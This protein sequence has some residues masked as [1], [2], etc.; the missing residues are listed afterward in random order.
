MP[1]GTRRTTSREMA[2]LL[3]LAVVIALVVTDLPVAAQD[4]EAPPPW[5]FQGEETRLEDADE[6]PGRIAPTAGQRA[7][8]EGMGATARW[9]A[10]GTPQVLVR[11]GGYLATGLD[12]DPTR[13]ADTARAWLRANAELFRLSPA[14]VDELVLLQDSPLY[15]SPDLSWHKDGRSGPD[16]PDVA[17][18]VRFRQHFDGIPAGQD[19]MVV[20]GVDRGRIFWVSS[21][22]SDGQ[23]N[24]DRPRIS[25]TA[26]WLAAAEDVGLP[27]SATALGAVTDGEDWFEFDAEGLGDVQ[28]ARL[29][30][31]PTP[32]DGVRLAWETLLLDSTPTNRQPLAFTHFVDAVDGRVW[33]RHNRLHHLA[34]PGVIGQS[35]E[36]DNPAWTTFPAYPTLVPLPTEGNL[37]ADGV[38]EDTRERW[39][40]FAGEDCDRVV[41][42]A[43]GFQNTAS[44]FPWDVD[45]RVPGEPSTFTSRGNNANTAPSCASF[46]TPDLCTF[47]RPVAPDRDYEFEWTNQWYEESCSPAVFTSPQRNDIDAATIALFVGHNRMHDWAYYLGWTEENSNMQE[48]NFGKT[49]EVR[50]QDPETG[51]TQ[52]GWT[53]GT[54]NPAYGRDNA[55][56]I[57]PPDGI[58]GVTNQ[59]LWQPI[60]SAAYVPCVDG[61]YD[62]AVVAHEVGH[63]IQHRMTAGPDTGLSG[64][65]ATS[66]GE[67][68]SDLTAVEYLSGLGLIEQG[69][70]PYAVGA[71]VVGDPERGIRNH[72]MNRSPLNYSNI[73]YDFVVRSVHSNGEIW[74]AA[75]H[76][77]REAL[78]AKYD[79][80][81]PAG[82]QELQTACAEGQLPADQCP[83]NRRWIQLMHDGFLLQPSQTTMVDARDA[84]LA[85]DVARF[86]GANQAEL[87]Q[88]FA[89]R[90]L[91]AEAESPEFT[92]ENGNERQ[93]V[94]NVDPTPD[95]TSP[96]ADNVA[97][98]FAPVAADG[99][100]APE[101]VRIFVGEYEARSRPIA[102]TDPATDL[103]DSASFA[104]DTYQ[105]LA[106]ADGFAWVRF[107][108]PLAEDGTIEIPMQRNVASRH[109]GAEVTSHDGVN[110]NKLIDDSEETNWASL[111]SD[112]TA[113]EPDD[114]EGRQVT[115]RLAGEGAQRVGRVQVSAMLR[116]TESDD[117]GDDPE[118]EP[119]PDS[120]PFPPEEP[121]GDTGGQNRFSALR[122][123]QILAC[124]AEAGQDCATEEGFEVVYTSPDD[125]FPAGPFRPRTEE[126]TLRSFDVPETEATHVRLRVLTNQCTG[127]PEYQGD[128]DNDPSNATDCRTEA[129][130]GGLIAPQ[131]ENVRAAM[132]QVLDGPQPPVGDARVRR[133]AGSNRIETAVAV[134]R[135]SFPAGADTVVIARSDLYPDALAGS[136]LAFDHE[137]P[138][139]V[140]PPESLAAPVAAEIDRLGAST[141]ILLG[142]TDALS[143]AV[144][145]AVRAREPVETVRRVEGA[146][147]FDTAAAIAGELGGDEVFITEG[148]HPHPRRGWPDALAVAPLA[149]HTGTPILLVHSDALPAP[150]RR[151]L[152]GK[153]L[154]TVVGGPTAVSQRVFTEIDAVATTT[155]RVAGDDRYATAVAVAGRA[156]STGMGVG[157]VFAATGE[158]F[159]DALVAGPAVAREGGVFVLVPPADL[160]RSPAVRRFL[161]E[162]ARRIAQITIVGGPAAVSDRVEQQLAAIMVR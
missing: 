55:N 4:T 130:A 82:D 27:V 85:A 154:A 101:N 25:A 11:H 61:A 24:A 12:P 140:T 52:A 114:V 36:Q 53:F 76:D 116:P 109:Q 32:A 93:G 69:E 54:V 81:F 14:A 123:F 67:S 143:G 50:A 5:S 113:S 56:Q 49:S 33:K 21:S 16:N 40:W 100:E 151:A 18:A 122:S 34:G 125:A 146:T 98:T 3:L 45:P 58:P 148:A 47:D 6:R 42:E 92:D 84:I 57:T 119:G 44:P 120:P 153:R 138:I 64:H 13:A 141:A 89:R 104:P 66:M 78:I 121:E 7:I 162:R 107:D 126:L 83:G 128:L 77:I 17:H 99:G 106:V 41:G 115:V 62:M 1:A 144:A 152:E 161:D 65:Q 91:G 88:A 2:T 38:S 73:E 15:D 157:H 135:A 97:V 160:D 139:L 110:S 46:L 22:L 29:V 87:W 149:A 131:G 111:G 43:E 129:G 105:F 26:A 133:L 136:P 95:F 9:N 51:Q 150:T 118:E 159:V 71:Y 96:L 37:V 63:A 103:G 145:D 72:A 80:Q 31:L 102:D 94:E 20:V 74:S 137:A 19:G 28:R 117:P 134:S 124:N 30:A 23:L 132:L 108:Q 59:Y 10:L 70:N 48:T 86:G 158:E 60:A 39:C 35:D 142:G 90:G 112:G 8:V 68:W 79:E 75:H 156:E 155:E 127:T 147:R